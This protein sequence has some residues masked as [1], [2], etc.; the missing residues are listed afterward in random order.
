M[1]Q[2]SMIVGG[3]GGGREEME[4]DCPRFLHFLGGG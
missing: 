2:N 1:G 3:G 4:L